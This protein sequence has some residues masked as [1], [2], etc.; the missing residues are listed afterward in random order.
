MNQRPTHVAPADLP[1]PYLRIM[2]MDVMR[3]FAVLG[4]FLVNVTIFALP[5]DNAAVAVA[6]H[7]D[8]PLNALIAFFT[9]TYVDFVVV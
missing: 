5:A 8:D 9:D 2:Q 6:L 4:I 7:Y 1:A 3:G